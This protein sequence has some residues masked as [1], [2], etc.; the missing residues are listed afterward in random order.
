MGDR[1]VSTD[2]QSQ[3][4]DPS[5]Q[6][7]VTEIP[8]LQTSLNEERA[9]KRDRQEETPTGTSTDQQGEKRQRLNPYSE[10]E[11]PEGPTEQQ[12][13]PSMETLA[14]SFQPEQER[15]QGVEVTSTR[16]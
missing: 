9:K 15:Q 2:E 7:R 3:G 6:A 12:V 13:P 11:L 16:Q 14:S 5:T 4:Q 8:V 10:E 1:L